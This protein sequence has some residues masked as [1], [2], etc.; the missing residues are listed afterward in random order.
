MSN[1]KN[2]LTCPLETCKAVYAYRKSF[3][4]HL[5]S[6]NTQKPFRHHSVCEICGESYKNESYLYNHYRNFHKELDCKLCKIKFVGRNA[7]LKHERNIHA[8]NQARG[9]CPTC[10]NCK[11][12]A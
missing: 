9:P 11:Q 4:V 12:T 2:E 3:Q 5:K 7:L 1:H 8:T 10:T 6:H